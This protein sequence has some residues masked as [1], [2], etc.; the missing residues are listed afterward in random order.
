MAIEGP[1]NSLVAEV[2]AQETQDQ[3]KIK[4]D[5]RKFVELAR[6]S[7][8]PHIQRKEVNELPS[9]IQEA[10]SLFR[11]GSIKRMKSTNHDDSRSE[12]GTASDETRRKT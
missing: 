12:A 3:R 11:K 5:A 1:R 7:L 4:E 10:D 9:L 6:Y 8:L 2:M